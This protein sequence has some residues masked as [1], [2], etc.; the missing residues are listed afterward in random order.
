MKEIG[1]N[2]NE[3]FFLDY[4]NK[5][6]D[7]VLSLEG[8]DMIISRLIVFFTN[9]YQ[10]LD[11]HG[12]YKKISKYNLKPKTKPWITK[13]GPYKKVSKY[14]LKPKTKPWITT[15]IS[16]ILFKRYVTFKDSIKID[17]AHTEYKCYRNLLS[18]LSKK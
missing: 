18:T 16:V 17:E 5:D 10:L 2:S 4:F 7:N 11:K 9:M 3:E 13:H 1:I 6:G 14:N 15:S 8:N 12:P